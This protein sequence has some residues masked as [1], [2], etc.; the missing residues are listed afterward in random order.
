MLTKLKKFLFLSNLLDLPLIR[1]HPNSASCVPYSIM[2]IAK[3]YKIL[4]SRKRALKM[5]GTS[6][7]NG[8]SYKVY[9]KGIQT[10]GL[11]LKRIAFKFETIKK[12][13][14][15]NIPVVTVYHIGEGW[16]HFSIIIATRRE[17]HTALVTLNDSI[18][19]RIEIPF[20]LLKVLYQHD[21]N[22]PQTHIVEKISKDGLK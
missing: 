10:I 21:Q 19:G 9:A 7:R 16:N 1:Q 8:S 15:K 17:G 14:D 11:K 5:C 20:K 13:T 6:N 2:T 18:F 12:Y 22:K 4:L 3:H